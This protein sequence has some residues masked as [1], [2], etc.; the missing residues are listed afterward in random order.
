[1]ADLA[2]PDW[3]PRNDDPKLTARQLLKQWLSHE[4]DAQRAIDALGSQ[5]IRAASHA[6]DR[7]ERSSSISSSSDAVL[8]EL[9]ALADT[10]TPSRQKRFR[11]GWN[12]RPDAS[13]LSPDWS[14][15]VH[16]LEREK[17]SVERVLIAIET[18]KRKIQ[19]AERGLDYALA[20]IR[21]CSAALEAA[22]RELSTEQP[23][24]AQ[25]LSQTLLPRLVER[26]RDVAMHI[27]IT[28]H[29]IMA[30]KL[31]ADGQAALGDAIDRARNTSV[32]AL[33]T[34]IAA[35]RAVVRNRDLLEQ[36][37]ALDNTASAAQTAPQSDRAVEAALT[38][39]LEQA[40]RAINANTTA[41][42]LA[43][44]AQLD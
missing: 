19:D 13:S 44:G 8:R 20:L 3:P 7:L 27:A 38:D 18:D 37:E 14:G 43:H 32:A 2:A 4:Y 11:L 39:A 6:S 36:A 26:E 15:L 24:R 28:Q 10:Y 40:R 9:H 41:H 34:A 12:S 31:I 16:S 22:V 5:A 17:E 1:M 23:D 21:A 25:F 30:L 35:R 29:G 33:R 42:T